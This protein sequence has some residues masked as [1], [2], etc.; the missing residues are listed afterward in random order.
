[1]SSYVLKKSLAIYLTGCTVMLTTA[2][3]ESIMSLSARVTSIILLVAISGIAGL[4]VLFVPAAADTKL[5]C[6]AFA[7]QSAYPVHPTAGYDH[8]RYGVGPIDLLFEYEAF[9]S[10]FDS[11]DDDNGDGVQD[12]LAI[13]EWVAYEIKRYGEEP[14][15]EAP[16]PSPKRPSP[17]YEID[18]LSFLG[19]QTGVTEDDLDE[20]YKGFGTGN[21]LANFGVVNRGHLAMK[22]HGQ[23]ISWKAGCNT[24][25]FV[26]AV[27][28]QRDFNQG[29]WL[30]LEAF[31]GAAANKFGQVWVVTGPIFDDIS[32]STMMGTT[33]EIPVA[34][35]DAMF[36]I[37]IKENPGSDVP[38]T[39]AFIF[40]QPRDDYVKCKT[41]H[42]YDN[43]R[44]L[45]SI[46]EIEA[47][48]GLEFLRN[49]KFKS[50]AIRTTFKNAVAP[51][52][53]DVESTF[54]V[55]TCGLRQ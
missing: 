44:F 4:S 23:R 27:P 22:S 30:E 21:G 9:V 48:T 54:Y 16:T 32:N 43:A 33:G 18:E 11:N 46:S 35:P 13:P 52:L 53:W 55:I 49:V 38:D 24:H 3:W 5:R 8:D 10:S 19:Q 26:N 50:T 31:S 14:P 25:V 36:K 29:D 15:F 37:L 17:W 51:E 6:R 45:K 1:M 47:R 42:E 2:N 7:G 20:S 34:V 28:Q 40:P 41:S 39:L 12:L